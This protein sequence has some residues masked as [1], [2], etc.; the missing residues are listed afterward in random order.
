VQLVGT[1]QEKASVLSFVRP[2]FALNNTS[3]EIDVFIYALRRIA[4]GG[5]DTR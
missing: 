3:D 4:G 1:A 5:T 2:S